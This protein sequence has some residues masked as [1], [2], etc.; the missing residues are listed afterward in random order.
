M[1]IAISCTEENIE[2]MASPSFGRAPHFYMTESEGEPGYFV[3]NTQNKQAVQGAGIQSAQT[4]LREEA[5]V[6]ITGH[7]GPKA[8][9]VLSEGGVRIFQGEPKR[10]VKEAL[11]DFSN[12]KLV[13]LNTSDVEGHWV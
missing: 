13:E 7:C 4:I 10:T 9:R 6:L 3:P 11:L 8:F 2:K 5:K 12:N 1:K